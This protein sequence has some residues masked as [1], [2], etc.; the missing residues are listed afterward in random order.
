MVADGGAAHEGVGGE[1][2]ESA[3]PDQSFESRIGYSAPAR[4][5]EVRPRPRRESDAATGDNAEVTE[6]RGERVTGRDEAKEATGRPA[7]EEKNNESRG[8]HYGREYQTTDEAD[9]NGTEGVNLLLALHQYAGGEE[10]G[11][12]SNGQ[13]EQRAIGVTEGGEGGEGSIKE[14]EPEQ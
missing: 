3:V 12:E 2:G 9:E 7:E 4:G 14:T 1:G 5:N 11:V 13:E 8:E 6:A 10:P